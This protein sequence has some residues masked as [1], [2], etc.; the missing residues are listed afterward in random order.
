MAKM[1][2][3]MKA[4]LEAYSGRKV[5]SIKVHADPVVDGTWAARAVMNE[6]DTVDFIVVGRDLP[7]TWAKATGEEVAELIE[8]AQFSEWPPKAGPPRFFW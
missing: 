1:T 4:G 6:G 3:K 8:E 2:D 5:Q 7:D